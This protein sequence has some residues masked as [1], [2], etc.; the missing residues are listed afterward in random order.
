[1]YFWDY[2]VYRILLFSYLLSTASK[3]D[4]V[5]AKNIKNKYS[6]NVSY[7]FNRGLINS[8]RLVLT[9]NEFL[10]IEI[11]NYGFNSIALDA[12]WLD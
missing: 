12:R 9:L 2:P 8:C 5:R 10:N 1:M 4:Y 11:I 6:T 7:N 3:I